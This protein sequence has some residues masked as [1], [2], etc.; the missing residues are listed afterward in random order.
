EEAPLLRGNRLGDGAEQRAFCRIKHATRI[1]LDNNAEHIGVLQQI[2]KLLEY[3]DVP[4][5]VERVGAQPCEH[6][7]ITLRRRRPVL[8]VHSER[9]LATIR[10]FA[11][12]A[13]NGFPRSVALEGL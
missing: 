4:G 2:W 8:F 12:A 13:L 3:G 6:A 10:Q 9:Q 7:N 5:E 1:A 11:N